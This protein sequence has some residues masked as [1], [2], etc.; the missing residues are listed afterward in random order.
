MMMIVTIITNNGVP[1]R[2]RR[3]IESIRLWPR[4]RRRHLR[5]SRAKGSSN[6]RKPLLFSNPRRFSIKKID[7]SARDRTPYLWHKTQD[8]SRFRP[9]CE[10]SR[11]PAR[12]TSVNFSTMNRTRKTR[13]CYVLPVYFCVRAIPF[14]FSRWS[15]VGNNRNLVCPE[16]FE[17]S[18]TSPGP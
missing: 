9:D 13:Y 7:F 10:N 8:T 6:R 15:Y 16:I 18:E 14:V 5:L 4:R 17:H 12:P 1:G 2:C 3:L 11:F